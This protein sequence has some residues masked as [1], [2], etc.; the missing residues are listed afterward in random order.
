MRAAVALADREGLDAVSMGGLARHAGV[1]EASLYRHLSGYNELVT[2]MTDAVLS[3]PRA[4]PPSGAGWRDLLE[5]EARQEWALYR[6]HPWALQALATT[7]PPL[8]AGVLAAV[9][10]YFGALPDLEP[11]AGLSIYLLVSGY[12]Q[13]MATLIAAED[14]ASRTTGISNPQWWTTHLGKIAGAVDTD[15]YPWLTALADG[16]TSQAAQVDTW[17][18]FGL[19]RVLDGVAQ[20]LVTSR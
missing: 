17:F 1:S 13:G 16:A 4:D 12:V 7:R 2:R 8:G 15:R 11:Q 18:S 6:E 9:D 10:R 3:A 20:Y 19:S 14:H 5:H